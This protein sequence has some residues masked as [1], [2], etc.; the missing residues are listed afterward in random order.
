M[1]AAYR[2]GVVTSD[3]TNGEPDW[4]EVARRLGAQVRD[5]AL[6][7]QAFVHRSWVNEHGVDPIHSNERLEF[8]GDAAIGFAVGW[9]LYHRFPDLP[10]GQLTEMRAQVVR[11]EA[12]AGAAGRLRLGEY[13]LLGRGED[14]SGGRER[15]ANLARVF[16]AVVGAVAV[17]RGV[18]AARARAL[19]WLRDEIRALRRGPVRPDPKS[20]LQH[21]VQRRLSVTPRYR[22]VRVEGPEHERV[23]TMVVEVQ[24]EALGE[25]T[26]RTKRRAEQA[27]AEVA[28]ARLTV[29]S[30]E[31]YI[32]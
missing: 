27:A 2:C 3:Q 1:A 30:V 21:F 5:V 17:D 22:V 20:R 11:G 32:S 26:G 16:E 4:A 24:G 6:L 31:T 7:R 29:E 13:L 18:A 25:G 9:H 8:L 28:L 23:F 15:Q 12:L 19:Y 10:E 14:Q